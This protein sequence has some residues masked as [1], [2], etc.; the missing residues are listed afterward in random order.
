MLHGIWCCAK[1]KTINEIPQKKFSWVY[2]IASI[3]A[4]LFFNGHEI[5]R[6]YR[7]PIDCSTDSG[8]QWCFCMLTSGLTVHMLRYCKRTRLLSS[9]P[10]LLPS[11]FLPFDTI[12]VVIFWH[13]LLLCLHMSRLTCRQVKL[14]CEIRGFFHLALIFFACIYH[15]FK[16]SHDP[17]SRWRRGI[18]KLNKTS[19]LEVEV[20]LGFFYVTSGLRDQVST[21]VV[22]THPVLSYSVIRLNTL[23]PE[24]RMHTTISPDPLSLWWRRR[25]PIKLRLPG[26]S[27][28]IF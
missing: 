23:T 10:W 22:T 25:I 13:V 3:F 28:L 27:C 4:Q 8:C 11:S 15:C 1:L 2:D 17:S 6:F 18:R 7:T 26:K 21:Q 14:S 19:Y 24:V 16:I 20:W 5:R 9:H 12:V